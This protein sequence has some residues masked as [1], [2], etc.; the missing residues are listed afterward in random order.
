MRSSTSPIA[1]SPFS[2]PRSRPGIRGPSPT[3]RG[4]RA[5]AWC[6]PAARAGPSAGTA[7]TA[8][9]SAPVPIP[10]CATLRAASGSRAGGGRPVRSDG[11]AERG[12]HRALRHRRARA[13]GE[14]HPRARGPRGPLRTGD[15]HL[16]LPSPGGPAARGRAHPS[17]TALPPLPR[18][19]QLGDGSGTRGA[20]DGARGMPRPLSRGGLSLRAYLVGLAGAAMLPVALLAIWVS[21]TVVQ[22][23]R[24]APRGRM[25]ETAQALAAAVDRDLYDSVHTL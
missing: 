8:S 21:A 2:P 25:Q 11:D 19:P 1:R 15:A 12:R 23:Q 6:W 9:P 7:A 22:D 10:P 14:L 13:L 16:P 3:S 4:I 5:S 24:A 20:A 18:V 17:P